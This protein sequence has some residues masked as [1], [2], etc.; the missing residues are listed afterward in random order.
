[1]DAYCQNINTFNAIKGEFL[2][3]AFSPDQTR[4]TTNTIPAS[5]EADKLYYFT[6]KNPNF[7]KE[8]KTGCLMGGNTTAC[9]IGTSNVDNILQ[10]FCE[11]YYNYKQDPLHLCTAFSEFANN[12]ENLFI[13]GGCYLYGE[14]NGTICKDINLR[15]K[16]YRCS[17]T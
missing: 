8:M 15:F 7:I 11:S 5:L 6:K 12:E 10:E 14:P 13:T 16:G 4:C 2:K 17:F 3:Q 1:M 9:C